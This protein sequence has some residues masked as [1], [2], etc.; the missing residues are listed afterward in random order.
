MS[1]CVREGT[2]K[3]HCWP[4]LLALRSAS[5]HSG[6]YNPEC[7]GLGKE[8]QS[9][10]KRTQSQ[11]QRWHMAWLR[12]MYI[13]ARLTGGQFLSL[14]LSFFMVAQ[15]CPMGG[16]FYT[17]RGPAFWGTFAHVMWLSWEP[18]RWKT[19]NKVRPIAESRLFV[20]YA[21]AL[22]A[23][24]F[25][26]TDTNSGP[27]EAETSWLSP[28]GLTQA[29]GKGLGQRPPFWAINLVKSGMLAE[30]TGEG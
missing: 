29:Q 18:L 16:L 1:A 13:P 30:R 5:G 12:A 25:W 14:S 20:P 15:L 7:E 11:R 19:P 26:P 22:H 28:G 23:G 4:G 21:S 9:L 2:L 6:G 17:L 8:A 10:E 3:P 27:R 24:H